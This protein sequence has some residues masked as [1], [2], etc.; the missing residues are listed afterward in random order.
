VDW[1]NV[2]GAF[3]RERFDQLESLLERMKP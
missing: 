1:L 2:Y 3:W